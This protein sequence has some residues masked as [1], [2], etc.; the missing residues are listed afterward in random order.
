LPDATVLFVG[1]ATSER[2]PIFGGGADS[3]AVHYPER[4]DPATGTWQDMAASPGRIARVYHSVALLLPDGRVWVAG[5]NHDSDRN[6]GGVRKDDPNKGDA[7]ELRVEAYSPPYLFTVDSS[8]MTVP[9]PRPTVGR[10]LSGAGHSHLFRVPT[11]D[12]S[13]VRAVHLVRNGSSTHAFN[14]DQRL[15][16]LDIVSRTSG[17]LTVPMPPSGRVAPP[18]Y[19]MPFLLNTA[20][21][22]SIGRFVRVAEVYP[23]V[24]VYLGRPLTTVDPPDVPAGAD[25]A[26]MPPLVWD[27]GSLDAG[28][29]RRA[30]LRCRNVGTGPLRL[31]DLQ[32]GGDFRTQAVPDD[33][34]LGTRGWP[35]NLDA[36]FRVQ[37]ANFDEYAEVELRFQPTADHREHL[38]TDVKDAASAATVMARA[39]QSCV[40]DRRLC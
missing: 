11:P 1:G 2:L 21:T 39:P 33:P 8:G 29:T 20:G 4:Y 13:T 18:G 36:T 34:I 17:S 16:V 12:A 14:P 23:I 26:A 3:S 19:Y 24:A 40:G 15:V 22:P 32:V 28:K 31:S 27:L 37:G 25:P 7:R 38:A 30:L 9:A 6:H 5:S 10:T 35:K